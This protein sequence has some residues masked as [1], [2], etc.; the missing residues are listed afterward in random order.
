MLSFFFSFFFFKKGL[1]ILGSKAAVN[2]DNGSKSTIVFCDLD[3]HDH[4]E[5]MYF[6]LSTMTTIGYGVSDYYFGGW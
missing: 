4:M 6:S 2:P 5:A 3:L 1:S